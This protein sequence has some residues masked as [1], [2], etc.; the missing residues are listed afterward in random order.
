MTHRNV[1]LQVALP[2]ITEVSRVQQQLQ[3]Q[4]SNNHAD[5]EKVI[6]Q[7]AELDLSR[8]DSADEERAVAADKQNDRSF[9]QEKRDDQQKEPLQQEEPPHPYKGKHVDIRG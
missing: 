9:Q 4:H 2:K 8:P 7:K 1:E 6:Q 3:Q 5:F